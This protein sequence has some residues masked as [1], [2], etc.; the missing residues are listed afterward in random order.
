[1]DTTWAVVRAQPT[2]TGDIAGTFSTLE[3]AEI[4]LAALDDYILVRCD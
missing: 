1:M 2:G 3:R 4:L